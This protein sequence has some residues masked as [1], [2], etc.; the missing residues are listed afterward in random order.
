MIFL[1]LRVHCIAYNYLC[2]SHIFC[3][4]LSSED[5]P[6]EN[7]VSSSMEIG[8]EIDMNNKQEDVIPMPNQT[9]DAVTTF[10]NDLRIV[11]LYKI[12]SDICDL[13]NE[14]V[15]MKGN[16]ESKEY[17]GLDEGLTKILLTLDGINSEENDEIRQKRKESI[18]RIHQLSKLL[19]SKVAGKDESSQ[20]AQV[21]SASTFQE[22]ADSNQV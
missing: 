15:T 11:K 6:K 3:L 4:Q 20:T 18:N 22:T 19:K 9:K 5:F 7:V 8:S 14:I 10:D 21:E 13:E 16:K 17:S 2:N 1:K 12:H